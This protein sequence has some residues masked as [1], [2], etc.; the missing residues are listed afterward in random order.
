MLMAFCHRIVADAETKEIVVETDLT[1]LAQNKTLPGVLA[2]LPD[3]NSPTRTRTL[4][5]AVNPPS[6][7]SL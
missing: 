3:L 2:G 7:D 4:N 1:G 5:L 6:A